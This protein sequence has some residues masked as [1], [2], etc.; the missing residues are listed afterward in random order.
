MIRPLTSFRFVAA[1]L[2]FLHHCGFLMGYPSF[3][4][5]IEWYLRIGRFGVAFFFIL[6]GFILTYNYHKIFDTLNRNNFA[7]FYL[8][9]IA[10]IYPLHLLTFIVAVPLSSPL[11]LN[12]PFETILKAIANVMLLQSFIP[13]SDYYFSF[14]HVSWSLS[15]EMFFY[16]LFPVILWALLRKRLNVRNLL[17]GSVL[18]YLALLFI[19][20]V[21]LDARPNEWLFYI[22]PVARLVEFILGVMLGLIFIQCND[23]IRWSAK[24]FTV[25]ELLSII[26]LLAAVYCFANVHQTLRYSVV[27]LPFISFLIYVFAHQ[28]GHVSKWLS[29]KLF[30]YLGEI[31]F[32]FYMI[33]QVV[34]FYLSLS[35]MLDHYYIS[36]AVAALAISLLYSAIA[37][38]YFEIPMRNRIRDTAKKVKDRLAQ[39]S[40]QIESDNRIPY[41]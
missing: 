13:N 3:R 34:I 22:F 38:K 28:L 31:S 16:A 30:V 4:T 35:P 6:S 29:N 41:K 17:A 39:R 20:I 37:Y 7:W 12:N 21:N 36:K 15:N 5:I 27:F 8:N 33:H 14:N 1:L 11:F 25:L 32:S 24:V 10:R 9:R 40:I 23:K 26:L 19:E 2:I 18:I